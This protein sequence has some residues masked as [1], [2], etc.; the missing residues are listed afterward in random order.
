[1]SARIHSFAQFDCTPP[2]G[3]P[4]P[5]IE[6]R[7]DLR[8]IVATN[9]IE[10]TSHGDTHFLRIKRAIQSDAGLYTCVAKSSQ[11]H[12]DSTPA[13]LIVKCK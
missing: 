9:R 7:K 5:T 1:M 8:L 3:N 13:Q 2:S 10:M 12:R 4:T 11:G 6:W